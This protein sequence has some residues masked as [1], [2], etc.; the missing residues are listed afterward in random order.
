VSEINKN[1]SGFSAVEGL[2]VMLILVV[3]GAVGYMVYHNNHTSKTV[4]STTT[5]PAKAVSKQPSDLSNANVV[6]SLDGKVQVKLPLNWKVAESSANPS[7]K[8]IIS[9]G[10]EQSACLTEDN[11]TS[12]SYEANFTPAGCESSSCDSLWNLQIEKTPDT[13]AQIIQQ[14]VGDIDPT[15]VGSQNNNDVNGYPAEYLEY[16]SPSTDIYYAVTHDGYAAVFTNTQLDNQADT[17]SS[18]QT[19]DSPYINQFESLVNSIK[20]NL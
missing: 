5:T 6:Y 7:S 1:E 19:T 16:S 9:N 20:I 12:C 17:D 15:Y 2:L 18:L 13:P 11:S 8:Q 3:I 4:A 10:S 14:E